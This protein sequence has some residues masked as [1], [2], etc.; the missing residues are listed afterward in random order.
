[1]SRRV[2]ILP[3]A[4]GLP[5]TAAGRRHA[6]NRHA[7]NI[8]NYK[9]NAAYDAYDAFLWQLFLRERAIMF[10]AK[11]HKRHKRHCSIITRVSTM[12]LSPLQIQSD[13]G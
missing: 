5:L 10:L 8:V 13:T 4:P 11:R 3:P 12:T 7:C 9:I 6:L 1:M 2:E